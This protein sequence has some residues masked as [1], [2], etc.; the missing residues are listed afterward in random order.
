MIINN[1]IRN[2]S[3]IRI[4][5]PE[6]FSGTVV[7]ANNDVSGVLRLPNA[8]EIVTRA[9]V[10]GMKELFPR[11]GSKSVA[12]AEKEYL[13]EDDFN[14]DRRGDSKDVGAYKFNASGNP[15]WKITAGFKESEVV[16]H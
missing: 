3:A 14:G 5:A 4:V 12:A 2:Q 7:V 9:N 1:T 10:T 13:P 15:G 8:N 11:A 16:Q 6:R